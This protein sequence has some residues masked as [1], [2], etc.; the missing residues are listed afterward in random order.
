MCLGN[1]CLGNLVVMSLSTKLSME[2]L[3]RL[4]VQL[5]STT[6]GQS[7][8]EAGDRLQQAAV[9]NSDPNEA[10]LSLRRVAR[11]PVTGL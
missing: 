1:L 10:S 8:G 2:Q 7:R 9:E 11:V 6:H 4:P 3:L 5:R